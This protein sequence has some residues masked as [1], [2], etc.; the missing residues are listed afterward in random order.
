ML[1]VL[2]MNGVSLLV[3][4]AWSA[5]RSR[6]NDP[7]VRW[8]RTVAERRGKKVAIT[9]LARLRLPTVCTGLP[10]AAPTNR[11]PKGVLEMAPP[12]GDV[13]A[14]RLGHFM[15]EVRRAVV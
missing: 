5:W 11:L 12:E 2:T 14:G 9:A 15:L 4:A 1:R 7:M 10:L 6:P 8:A 13:C 3:Q